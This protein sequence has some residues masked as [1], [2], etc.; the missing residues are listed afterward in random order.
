VKVTQVVAGT[1]TIALLEDTALSECAGQMVSLRS[2]HAGFIEMHRHEAEQVV[3]SSAAL[4]DHALAFLIR[5]ARPQISTIF[6]ARNVK[7]LS[8]S[9]HL[10]P[11]Q[12]QHN[13]HMD[14]VSVDSIFARQQADAPPQ[15]AADPLQALPSRTV[16]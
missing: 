12:A 4:A 7:T 6:L 10:W 3:C 14:M 8:G 5:R 15:N 2:H 9:S 13:M 1:G 16:H 11:Q